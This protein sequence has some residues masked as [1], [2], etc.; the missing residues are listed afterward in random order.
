MLTD[1]MA[2]LRA[3]FSTQL[4]E[5]VQV[6]SRE[7]L[8]ARR[9]LSSPISPI[10]ST[11]AEAAPAKRKPGRPRKNPIVV[12]AAAAKHEVS[13]AMIAASERYFGERG[14]KGATATQLA[15]FL[16]EH[17]LSTNADVI[18]ELTSRGTIRDAGFRRSTGVGNKTSA[19]FVK[20]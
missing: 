2:R 7:E 16:A 10:R 9:A 13:T 18:A 5:V 1:T 8:A 15:T 4:M 12:P 17:G 20:N 3:E 19:V 14:N 6:A 11:P